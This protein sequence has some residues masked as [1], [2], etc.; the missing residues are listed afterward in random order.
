[1]KEKGK[2]FWKFVNGK[3]TYIGFGL[4]SLLIAGKYFFPQYIDDSTSAVGH[5]IIFSITG[6]GVGHKITKFFQSNLGK[7]AIQIITGFFKKK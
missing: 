5:Q 3:K 2:K 7:K 1:M 4:H 6:V